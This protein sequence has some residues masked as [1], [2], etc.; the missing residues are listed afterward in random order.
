MKKKITIITSLAIIIALAVA[1][2]A[3]A[4]NGNETGTPVAAAD[5]AGYSRSAEKGSGQQF[6]VNADQYGTEE[7]F[8]AAVLTEKLAIIELKV[9][10]GSLTRVD[11]DEMIEYLTSCDGTCE[12]EGENPDRPVDGWGIFGTGGQGG[13]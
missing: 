8:H 11:A 2:T 9:F 4:G 12:T 10:D 7:E 6:T 13:N 1:G 3:L 5:R